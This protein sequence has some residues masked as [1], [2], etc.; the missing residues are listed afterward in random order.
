MKVSML[1]NNAGFMWAGFAI[2]SHQI[3]CIGVSLVFV[4]WGA[5]LGTDK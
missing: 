4:I 2:A 1:L 5:I 3:A